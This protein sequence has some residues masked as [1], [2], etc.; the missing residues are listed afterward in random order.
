MID[1]CSFGNH[2]C[3]HECV[4]VLNG[5]RCRCNEGYRLLEDGKTCQAIDLCAEGKH[6]CEQI[7]I[8][9]AGRLHLRLQQRIH[10]Q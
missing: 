9:A 3:D 7:C 1:Y 6:D 2:S 4:S 5:Y 10:A 8:S